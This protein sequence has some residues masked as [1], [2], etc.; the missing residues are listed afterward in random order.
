MLRYKQL[1]SRLRWPA[2]VRS[3]IGLSSCLL[4]SPLA[5]AATTLTG[6][7]FLITS[8]AAVMLFWTGV[9]QRT[10]LP[11]RDLLYFALASNFSIVGEVY[12]ATFPVASAWFTVWN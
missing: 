3:Q 4:T 5:P 6:L 11:I 2:Q 12:A 9:L 7:H 1:K 8:F 10:H